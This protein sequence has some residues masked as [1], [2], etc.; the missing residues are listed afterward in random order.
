MPLDWTIR[1]GMLLDG[2]AGFRRADLGLR[3]GRIKTIAPHLAPCQK[4]DL[5]VTGLTVTSGFID[6]HCHSEF[7]AFVYP[8]AESKVLAGVTTDVSGNCGSSP[9]PLVGEFKAKRQDEWKPYGLVID[10]ESAA[11]YYERAEAAPSSV[12]R[13]LLAGHGAIRS[14][15]VGYADRLPTDEERRRMRRLLAEAL[16]LGAFGLSSGLI[17]PPGCYASVTVDGLADLCRV[18][19]GAGGFYASHIR[20]EGDRLLEAI[21]EFLAVVHTSGVRGQLSHLKSSGEANW[22]KMDEAIRRLRAARAAGMA[23]TADRY[24]YLASMTDLDSLLLPNWAVEG[25]RQRELARLADPATRRKIADEIR[26]RHPQP[27]YFDRIRI[28]SVRP[29]GPQ[30]PVGKTLRQFGDATGRDPLD[31]AFDLI[32][33][34]ETQATAMAFTMCEANLRAVLAE[35]YVAIGSDAGLRRVPEGHEKVG[36]GLAHP[37]AY[38]TPA[39]FLGTYVREAGL[40]DWKEGIRRLTSLPADIVGLWNRGRLEEGAWADLVIFDRGTIADAAT[41]ERPWAPPTGIRHVF[42]NGRRV[43]ADG[44]HTGATPGRVLRRGDK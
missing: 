3:D 18:V 36:G 27:D 10:W 22:P 30:E 40:M 17:Y 2:D 16:D 6:I 32:V 35:P 34:S 8:R 4:G 24:P 11:Q 43:V 26:A 38:G 39:R 1:G 33:E 15:V 21:D 9:F 25:G 37:R 29:D 5:D 23:V 28:A 12:N 44:V 42:V 14:A 7:S 19:A 41:Y 20:S 13:A 31:A